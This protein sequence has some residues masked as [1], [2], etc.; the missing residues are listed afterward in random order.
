MDVVLLA[1]GARVAEAFGDGVEGADHVAVRL[2]LG[3]RYAHRAQLGRGQHRAGPGA[4][5]LGGDVAAGHFAQVGVDVVGADRLP[6][7][8]RILEL[9]E[10]FPGQ[11]L[12]LLDDARQPLVGDRQVVFHAALAAEGKAQH[13]ARDLHVPVAQ[14]SQPE[15]PVLPRVFVVADPDQRLVEQKHHGGEDLPA[16]QV[17]PAQVALHPLAQE[18]KDL[19][20][21][22]HAPELRLVAHFPVAR[23]IP[24]LLSSAGVARGDLDMPFWMRADPD[25]GPRRR[26]GEREDSAALLDVDDPRAAGGDEDPPA[27]RPLPLD[28]GDA[29]GHIAQPRADGGLAMLVSAGRAHSRLRYHRVSASPAD[30]PQSRSPLKV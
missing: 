22:E 1:D 21:L 27:A 24:V 14:R 13:R 11:V 5:V 6:L 29:V 18:R 3:G 15:R 10:L 26:D 2:A 23:V 28:A 17:V 12:A 7:P 4:E 9:E 20:E 30:K 19:A 25:V 16:A 8:V